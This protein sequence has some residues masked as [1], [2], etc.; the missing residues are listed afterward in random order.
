MALRRR[1]G[2]P[3]P[4]AQNC[5][6]RVL[7]YSRSAGASSTRRVPQPR[8][9]R[10]RRFSIVGGA[11]RPR[12]GGPRPRN[13]RGAR[14][15]GWRRGGCS[16][17][18][19]AATASPSPRTPTRT[20]VRLPWILASADARGS[21]CTTATGAAFPRGVR[22]KDVFVNDAAPAPATV[23]GG[24]RARLP[25]LC[26]DLGEPDVHARAAPLRHHGGPLLSG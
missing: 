4:P 21:T 11:A 22:Q 7:I 17:T 8:R 14:G 25:A 26:G 24:G 18:T 6:E 9:E 10:G 23:R 13:R 16:S 20:S 19:T 1:A 5:I 2:A 3:R 12:I 15:P